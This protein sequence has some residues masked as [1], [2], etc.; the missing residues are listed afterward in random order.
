MIL[1]G[2]RPRSCRLDLLHP[3]LARKTREAQEQ[4]RKNHDQSCSYRNLETGQTVFVHNF[5]SGQDWL[6]GVVESQTGP[7]SF[8]VKLEDG[9]LVKRHVDHVRQR[10]T[11]T[12][13][14][15]GKAMMEDS[16]DKMG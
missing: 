12:K 1:M 2:R 4:Q 7:L 11:E 15:E 13:R 16:P 5:G 9:R 8:R 10:T 6:A 14:P 3:D